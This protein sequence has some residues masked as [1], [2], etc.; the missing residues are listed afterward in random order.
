[1]TARGEVVASGARAA[2][3]GI[4][5]EG[6][7]RVTL[8]GPRMAEDPGQD[9]RL[10]VELGTSLPGLEGGRGFARVAGTDEVLELDR[11]PRSR[12]WPDDPGRRLPPLLDERLLAGELPDLGQGLQRAFVDLAD[13]RS[14][15]VRS[16]VLGP[17]PGPDQPPPREWVALEGER[18][19]RCLPYRI[20][21]WQSFLYRVPYGGVAPTERAA[22]LGLDRPVAQVTLLQVDGEPIELVVGRPG[23]SGS[24]FVW[25]KATDTLCLLTEDDVRLLLPTVDDLRSTDLEN[26]WEAWLPR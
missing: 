2:A 3:H 6:G 9:A 4:G 20:G 11:D 24:T 1:V 19:A 15:E 26:P 7:L 8:H 12:L 23:S 18:T 16:R 13:G 17:A 22:S 14:L 5:V 25:N 21:G 10:V